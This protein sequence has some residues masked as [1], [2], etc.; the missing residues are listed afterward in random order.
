MIVQ[1]DGWNKKK[2]WHIIYIVTITASIPLSLGPKVLLVA[3]KS[4]AWV[5]GEGSTIGIFASRMWNKAI[6]VMLH[7]VGGLTWVRVSVDYH[8]K[9][10]LSCCS[11]RAQIFPIKSRP[12]SSVQF[13]VICFPF[14]LQLVLELYFLYF[15]NFHFILLFILTYSALAPTHFPSNVLCDFLI[16][17]LQLKD[18][19]MG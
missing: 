17:I 12:S 3:N 2:L 10:F 15:L 14:V 4:L 13:F 18:T 11:S 8:V 19:L 5:S 1:Q 16:N 9:Y 7:R 6:K